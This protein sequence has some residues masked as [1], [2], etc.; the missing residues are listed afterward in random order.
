MK[1]M[2][3]LPP[4]DSGIA[5]LVIDLPDEKVNKLSAEVM[6]ELDTLLDDELKNDNIRALIVSSG[7]PGVFV[8]GADIGELETLK[9]ESDAYNKSQQGQG[10]FAKLAALKYHTI[11]VI[12]GACMGGGLE[13]ALACSFRVVTDN[14]KTKL[15]L[16]EVSLGILPGWGGTQR[17]PRLVGLVQALTMILS[18]KPVSGSK[19][20]RIGLADALVAH[21]FVA[22]QARDFAGRCLKHKGRHAIRKK[23]PGHSMERIWPASALVINKAKTKAMQRSK[24]HYPAIPAILSLMQE[25]CYG[26][27]AKGM[28]KESAAFSKLATTPI[29]RNLIGLFHADQRLKKER[30][31]TSAV[32]P[33]PLHKAAILGAGVMG[34]GIAWL[35]SYNGRSVRVK[36]VS[37]EAVGKAF[38]EAADY[39]GQL[40][41]LRKMQPREV[42]LNMHRITGTVDY[43]GFGDADVLVE[44]IVEKMAA[45]KAVL[46]EVEKF[47]SPETVICSNTSALSITE[48]A[49]VLQH[50]TRFVGMHFFNPVNRMPLVEVIAG[51]ES[52]DE[53]V[54]TVVALAHELKKTPVVVKDSPG[55]LVNRILIPYLNEAGLL[56]QEGVDFERIDKLVEGFGMPMGPFTLADETGIDVGY[57]VI[58]ELEAAFSPRL[59]A[60]PVLERFIKA[61]LLGRKSG[62]GFY[63]HHGKQRKANPEAVKLLQG[64]RQ[65]EVSDEDIVD[66]LILTMLNE[67]AMCLQEGVVVRVDYL[68][69]ALITG[70][71][72]PPFRGGLLRY[73]DERG[74]SE[75]VKR[76]QALQSSCG[77][78]FSPCHR[79]LS[80]ASSGESFYGGVKNG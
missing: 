69:M 10:V 43:S 76:L 13:L 12:D 73:A 26:S 62:G 47:V 51:E 6:D 23:R 56:L 33:W 31:V 57:K 74:I 72:F 11:A 1:T 44:A 50:P 29:C 77:E 40:V 59:R 7:K 63:L 61:G 28:E 15:G 54:A 17:L 46:A 16:P 3:L 58:Q 66:R 21:E 53:T 39:Y 42:T 71:G 34:G 4:D 18:G 70:I 27:L 75:V 30:G 22:E 67:A 55:F 79:L 52:S 32:E 36:D 14:P 48:M 78:R 5:H 80:M 64:F 65:N 45:K 49:T 60:A 20:L 8:A 25:T 9:D 41:K 2:N 37:W 35:F 68:D 24:G 38:A 19:A